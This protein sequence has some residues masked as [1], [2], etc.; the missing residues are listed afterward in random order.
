M[1]CNPQFSSCS[2]VLISATSFLPKREIIALKKWKLGEDR[3]AGRGRHIADRIVDETAS[4]VGGD[5]N[6]TLTV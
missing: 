6:G 4:Q 2:L 3:R 5:V 1:L